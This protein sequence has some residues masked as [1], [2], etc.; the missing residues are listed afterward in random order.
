MTAFLR[1]LAYIVASPV[2][3]SLHLGDAFRR[4]AF[5]KQHRH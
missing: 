1:A 3:L 2:L 5:R 4:H